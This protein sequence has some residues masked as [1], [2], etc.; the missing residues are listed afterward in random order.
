MYDA[1]RVDL[2]RALR[3]FVRH[4]GIA[5]LSVAVLAVGIGLATATFALVNAAVLRPLPHVN[6]DR[7]VT[8]VTVDAGQHAASG[9]ASYPQFEE[10]KAAKGLFDRVALV[11]WN[12]FHL[13]GVAEPEL[14]SGAWV[15]Q[16]YFPLMGIHPVVG[17]MLGA[18]DFAAQ[19]PNVVVVSE[20]LWRRVLGGN[21]VLAAASLDLDGRRFAVVGVVRTET[22]WPANADV[23]MPLSIAPGFLAQVRRL[24]LALFHCVAR[25][26]DG[27][28]LGQARTQVAA[29]A[30]RQAHDH[31]ELPR[32]WKAA[33][34]P[35]RD[36]L[37]APAWRTSLAVLLGAVA[38]VLLL[39]CAN[40]ANLL[41]VRTVE[42]RRDLAVRV[43]LGASPASAARELGF[44]VLC[45]TALSGALGL[46]L[47][48]L[49]VGAVARMGRASLP[50]VGAIG[51][52]APVVLFALGAAALVG[53]LLAAVP[54]VTAA[55]VRWAEALGGSGRTQAGSLPGSR[56]RF[57]LLAGEVALSIVLLAG[58]GLMIRSFGRL[59]EVN[60]GF[61]PDRLVSLR[62][63]VPLGRYNSPQRRAALGDRMIDAIGSMPGV[64]SLTLASSLPGG[65]GGMYFQWPL[66]VDGRP[67]PPASRDELA[68]AV[69]VMPGHFR[70]IGTRLL[71]GRDFDAR[72]TDKSAPVAIV[73]RELARRLFPDG[74]DP[75]GR[76]VRAWQDE[77]TPREIVGVVENVRHLQ[78]TDSVRPTVYVP[79]PQLPVASG[80]LAVRLS[81]DG[82]RVRPDDEALR[83]LRARIHA[84][85][86]DIAILDARPMSVVAIEQRGL[87]RFSML[88]LAV[89]ASVGTILA[90]VGLY[91]VV[92]YT[93]ARRTR[94]FGVRAALGAGRLD[95]VYAALRQALS[96]IACGVGVGLGA[97]MALSRVL[98]ALVYGVSVTDPAAYAGSAIVF[99]AVALLACVV[100]AWRS[101]SID[102][103]RA[104]RCE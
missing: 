45:I 28:T 64:A 47:A 27:V 99:F 74:T 11:S 71:R 62:L 40:A 60:P 48:R 1:V 8:P 80:M 6:A 59:L 82:R 29:I 16:D 38:F 67:D 89:L 87:A 4:P 43:A 32:T 57:L 41:L 93:A 58:A 65:A 96:P 104:L 70:T 86:P 13:T 63:R 103:V 18:A 17:R 25:L 20:R 7:L 100:P 84:V 14:L 75:V 9:S 30:A 21:A 33:V 15:S 19:A 22:L 73:S 23:W 88:V 97:A 81:A 51:V 26:E 68:Q 83:A 52:D 56:S 78:W 92:S 50:S 24:D 35:I 94:E 95:L 76:K 53:A 72:D 77:R 49:A 79:Q 98:A 2:R 55:R 31:P 54:I 5:A 10:W 37:I 46:L 66:I 3:S 42:R 101:S 12:E 44:E 34:L 39:A 85:E 91:G 69:V 36:Q 61:A 90:A 102:P